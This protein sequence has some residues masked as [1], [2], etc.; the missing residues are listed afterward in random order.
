MNKNLSITSIAIIIFLLGCLILPNLF[1]Y[2]TPEH[3]TRAE[4]VGP[5]VIVDF[6]PKNPF[7]SQPVNI[8]I[9]SKFG[10]EITWAYLSITFIKSGISRKGNY[11]FNRINKTNW[12]VIIP[13]DQNQG[14]TRVIFYATI[15]F[16]DIEFKTE[17]H[18]YLVS[19]QGS[20]ESTDFDDNLELSYTPK[21]PLS[22]DPVNVTIKSKRFDVPIEQATLRIQVEFPGG[23]TPKWGG[24]NFTRINTT[25][26]Y[27]TIP[28]Y[29]SGTNVTFWVDAFDQGFKSITSDPKNY[30]VEAR[31][32]AGEPQFLYIYL[33]DDAKRAFIKNAKVT[34]SN[35]TWRYTNRSIQG[36]VFSPFSLNPGEYRVE[37][38]YEGDKVVRNIKLPDEKNNY[39][40]L[41][42]HFNIAEAKGLIIEFEDFPQWFVYAAFLILILAAPVFYYIYIELQR[43][44][45]EQE[46]LAKKRVISERRSLLG[47]SSNR[48]SR[49]KTSKRSKRTGKRGRENVKGQR[50]KEPGKKDS[51]KSS[52]L[53]FK[54][55]WHPGM[56]INKILSNENYKLTTV[57]VLG[58]FILGIFGSTWA[59]FYPWW[60]VLVIGIIAAAI[61][62]R[63]PYLALIILL[64]FVI[65]S[66]A[67]QFPTFGWLFMMFSLII[68][69]CALFDWRFGFLVF[70]TLFVS[71]LGF[72]FIVPIM[73]G[74][75][76]SLFL[77][78]AVAIASG[79]FFTFLVSS[80]D[81]TILSFFVGPSHD[82]GFITF[83]KPHIADFMPTDFVDAIGSIWDVNFDSMITIMHS[84]Y[85]SMLPFIQIIVLAVVV[86]AIVYLFQ[87]YG[88]EN[89]KKSMMLS[90]VPSAI[91]ILS[92]L[93]S[94]L[95]F[96]HELNIGTVLVLIGIIGVMCSAIVFSFMSMELFKEFYL[97]KTRDVAIGTRIG[98][99]L[100]LRKT[101]FTQIGGLKAIKRELKDTMIGPLLR[102]KK[103]QEYGVEP[104]RGIM[105]FGPPGCGKTLLMRALATE[106][107]VEMI[108]VRCSDVMSKWYGES[109]SMIEK[110]FQEVKARKPCI[111]FLDEI[112]A[113]AKRRDFYSADDVTPRLLS[114]MLSELDGMD[115]ASGVI[116]VG[117]TNKPELVDPA[118]MR[119]GR[120]DKIIFI[121]AP[122]YSSRI[123]IFKIH[124]KGKPVSPDLDVQ[125]IARS[126]EGFSG[127][128]IENLVK[129]AATL[130]M[131]R[132]IKLRR[133]TSIT[134]S[135]FLKIL[136]RIKPSLSRE[137]KL[138]Y[139]K[140]QADFERK[141]YGEEIKLPPTEEPERGR[142]RRGV[143]GKAPRETLRRKGISGRRR[144]ARAGRELKESDREERDERDLKGRGKKRKG[145]KWKDVVGLDNSKRFF[146]S[147]IENNL[148]GGK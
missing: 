48:E 15:W 116:V 36:I 114:I 107:N 22:E 57:R 6:S 4:P 89:V 87:R 64:M 96:D 118:L 29:G 70:L 112:D 88:K 62:Y 50:L 56:V 67:Y 145:S 26:M 61:S 80:G 103:A 65:G 122:D 75:L 63:Y 16:E 106:L 91:I 28:G 71:R 52:L 1:S 14:D 134:N 46:I 120:F 7:D 23:Y 54:D 45:R 49:R 126:S 30:I 27:A 74:V 131:K 37:V 136:P 24:E 17:D 102:P 31:P 5:E 135:D 18:E 41:E 53:S 125:H 47:N 43:K 108:G 104:P 90:L 86:F 34:I 3:V 105:M 123:E 133:K 93:S 94:I 39:T 21:N 83:S 59:P 137:M 73:T 35:E 97:G 12:N 82:Y 127:A 20:W 78:L 51:Y 72:A 140:L 77:G 9:K 19:Y 84:N 85:T 111:L 101:S 81:L 33:Y 42:L 117:A 100:T 38:N 8:S 2:S 113:I 115:E 92:S 147:T 119:P 129:E 128:D 110:L 69:I 130:A 124:L 58:F 132:S 10:E 146:R 11:G 141:K 40:V 142:G 144:K 143:R 138:E 76:L 139:D 44:A 95:I 99:M 32:S 109:E 79:I 148:L 25:S 98:E 60:M 121:P 68:A 66:T 13:A 55:L